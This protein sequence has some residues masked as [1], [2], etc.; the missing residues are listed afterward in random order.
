M[1]LALVDDFVSGGP[2]DRGEVR[3]RRFSVA[4]VTVA[5]FTGDRCW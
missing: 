5:R 1:P 3:Q 2:E 4:G